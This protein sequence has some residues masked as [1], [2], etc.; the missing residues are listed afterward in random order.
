MVLSAARLNPFSFHNTAPQK[1]SVYIDVCSI[2]SFVLSLSF[3]V[4]RGCDRE[5]ERDCYVIQYL[6][7]Y[8]HIYIAV[9]CPPS[10][11]ICIPA[12]AVRGCVNVRIPA[13]VRKGELEAVG[14]KDELQIEHTEGM[15]P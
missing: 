10:L 4:P 11:Y 6:Y 14:R 2:D 5:R 12:V 9:C 1:N 13:G 7:L 15:R 3:G 8:T